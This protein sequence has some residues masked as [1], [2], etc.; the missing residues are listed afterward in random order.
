MSI[1]KRIHQQIDRRRGA[2]LAMTALAIVHSA[3]AFAQD[4]APAAQEAPAAEAAAEQTQA[5]IVITGSRVARSGYQSPTPLTVLSTEDIQNQSPTNNIADFI[6]QQPALAGSTRP[7]NSRLN[8]SSGQAGINALNLRNLGESRTLVLI[9]GRR[10]VASTITGLVDVNTIPQSLVKSVE[11]VTGGASAAY[12]SDAVAGVVNFILDKKFEGLKV[13]VDSGITTYGDG[14]NNSVSVAAGKSFAGGRGHILLS[15]EYDH[16]DGIFNVDRDWNATGYVRIQDPNWTATSTTP[17]Y[18]IRRQVGAANSTPGGLITANSVLAGSGLTAN[19]LRGLYFGQGGQVLQYNFGALTFPSPTGSAAPTLTQGGSWQV[20]DS[21]R[22]IGLDPQDDRYGFYGRLSYEVADGIELFAEGS[23][24]HQHILFNAGPNLQTGIALKNDNAFLI[25]TLGASRLAGVNTV[26]VATTAA[27]LPYREADNRRKV[28]RYVIGADGEFTLFGKSAHWDVF[29]QYGRADLREQLGNIMNI[30]R[31]N[32]ATDAVFA[33]AGNPGGYAAGSIQCRIN[34]DAITTNDDKSCVPLNRL[35]LGVANPA[36]ISY[37]LGSPYRDE[38]TEEW[39]TGVNLAFTPFST[40]AGDVSVALGGEWREE[41]ISGF[42]PNEYQPI[43]GVD[44]NGRATTSNIWSVGNYLPTNG[45]YNVKEAYLETVVPL[46]LGLE[47]NGAV[48]ATDYST[49]GYV[50]TWKLGATWQPIPDF[51]FRV[52]RSRDIRAP[53]LNELYQA[54]SA[55]SDAVRNPFYDGTAANGP[56][57]YSYSA[58]A[59]GNPKLRPEIADSLTIGA[60]LSPR[61][62]RGFNASIDYFRIDVT[63]A[64]SSFGAQDIINLCQLGQQQFCDAYTVDPSRSTPGQPYLLFRTQ[65][66]NA[67]SQLVRGIDFDASYRVPLGSRDSIT[68]RGT[69]TRYLDNL[70]DSGVPGTVVTNSVGVNGGQYSTPSW[71]YHVSLTYDTPSTS[72][73][74]VARGISSGKYS[75]TAIECQTNCPLSTTT[76]P[77]YESNHVSGLFYVDLN[78]A[79]RITVNSKSDAQFFINVTNLFDR[80]P[81]LVP[82]TGLAAN[83]TYSDLLGRTFRVGVRFQLH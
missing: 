30:G 33:Q 27:D 79:R 44:A 23:Y 43:I 11:I 42:V 68:L 20:N 81:L 67:A 46:G 17:Q 83:S 63:D 19:N 7:S 34:V 51:R 9:D 62:L 12:G 74:A 36:A 6:N 14:G 76:Y 40:W 77:T 10:S 8:L 31:M 73:T 35:G 5:D 39:D 54:G 13:S 3:P 22:R 18:L 82:E 66:F 4:N 70:L 57:S 16:R 15:G 58:V 72:I 75:A 47:F 56:A 65:P 69:A 52:V 2:G 71:I 38:T 48:R 55:N 60:V 25:N 21:G 32:N 26:T 29:G 37:V 59:T 78:L 49:A 1:L 80:A 61:F 24:N 50:T 28:Q 53:N 45:S 64:I 41:K